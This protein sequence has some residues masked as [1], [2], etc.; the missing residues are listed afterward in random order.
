MNGPPWSSLYFLAVLPLTLLTHAAYEPPLA[1]RDIRATPDAQLSA[2]SSFDSLHTA[3]E[4]RLNNNMSA[5]CARTNTSNQFLQIDLGSTYR[6]SRVATQGSPHGNLTGHVTSYKISYSIDS[7]TWQTYNTHNSAVE[8]VFVGNI[9]ESSTA[10]SFINTTHQAPLVARTVKIIPV[11]WRRHICLR[12][13]LFGELLDQCKE[14]CHLNASCFVNNSYTTNTTCVCRPGFTGN[15]INCTDIDECAS[16]N[17]CSADQICVNTVGS[18]ACACHAGF[19]G[20][21]CADLDEC[22]LEPSPCSEYA[23]CRNTIGSFSC[24]CRH[25][26][27][28]FGLACIDVDECEVTTARCHSNASCVNTVGSYYCSCH[29]GYEMDGDTG[30]CID[31]DECLRDRGACGDWSTCQNTIGSYFCICRHGYRSRDGRNC[32]VSHKLEEALDFDSSVNLAIAVG[33]PVVAIAV[34]LALVG[35]YFFYKSRIH[36]PCHRNSSPHVTGSR[37]P[38]TVFGHIDQMFDDDA[39]KRLRDSVSLRSFQFNIPSVRHSLVTLHN[40]N[41]TDNEKLH[42]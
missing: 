39:H 31:I 42:I 27:T 2:S 23:N 40:I 35:G 22:K 30:R 4:G 26:F 14:T 6:I 20:S 1:I 34:I 21:R 15:G 3:T 25:G 24:H 7:V 8:Q 29:V 28:G 13:E 41:N 16:A 18:Y 12:V 5:W 33:L 32:T 38:S 9:D 37:P 19:T 36:S 17:S 10:C 11:T